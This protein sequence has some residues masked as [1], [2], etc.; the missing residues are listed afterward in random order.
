MYW[1]GREIIG[2]LSFREGEMGL[3]VISIFGIGQATLPLQLKTLKASTNMAKYDDASWHYGGDYP[4]D[5]PQENGATHIGMFLTWCID[6]DL[7]SEFLIEQ[8]EVDIKRVKRRE[9]TGA[10]FLIENC[11]EKFTDEDLNE[12]GNEFTKDYFEGETDFSEKFGNYIDDY[13]ELFDQKAA[14]LGFEYE[15]L[16][17]IENTF[18]NYQLVKPIIDRRFAEW[19]KYRRK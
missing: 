19:K 3:R 4:N 12:L 18:E 14:K 7:Q 16:Y 17:H 9:R 15:T 5:L 1:V 8:S 10:E 13:C 6:N 2:E 11:D